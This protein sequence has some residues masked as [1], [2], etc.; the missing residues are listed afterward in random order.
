MKRRAVLVGALIALASFVF[1]LAAEAVTTTDVAKRLRDRIVKD[2]KV[3]NLEIT[4]VPYSQAETDRG[5]FKS[6]SVRA[7][8]ASKAGIAMRPMY[9]KGLDVVFDLSRLFG[10]KA[11]V[12][13][14]SR[15]QTEMYVVLNEDDLNEGLRM[16]QKVVPDLTASLQNGQI[17]LTGTYKFVVGNKFKMSGKLEV[18][19]GYRINFVP[20]AVK[21][22]GVPLPVSGVKILL[23]K[24]NPILDLSDVVMEPRVTSL[25]I[26]EGRLIVK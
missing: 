20:T 2:F 16:A 19:D 15:G 6:V 3:E 11:T 24:L 26:E 7:D 18:P 13:T 9:V 10:P 4:V 5:R 21:V 8:C 25:S 17:T 12:R 1:P 14:K 23:S 22:N